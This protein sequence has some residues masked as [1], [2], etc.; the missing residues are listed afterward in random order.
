M[1]VKIMGQKRVDSKKKEESETPKVDT[2]LK[3]VAPIFKSGKEEE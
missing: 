1:E 2:W 3:R